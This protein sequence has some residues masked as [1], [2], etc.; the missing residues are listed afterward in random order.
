MFFFFVCFFSRLVTYKHNVF[1]E[2]HCFAQTK[3]FYCHVEHDFAVHRNAAASGERTLT[4]SKRKQQGKQIES[5]FT[6]KK[7]KKNKSP[8][9]EADGEKCDFYSCASLSSEIL[10]VAGS[11]VS[12]CSSRSSSSSSSFESTSFGC[13]L[14]G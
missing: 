14:G 6:R 12:S 1:S 9:T 4:K 2:I 8:L 7:C 3:A 10:L 13:V 11:L 5:H